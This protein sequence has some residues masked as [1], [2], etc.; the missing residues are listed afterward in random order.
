MKMSVSW[1]VPIVCA[2]WPGL[3]SA[4]APFVP[5]GIESVGLQRIVPDTICFIND[6]NGD[7]VLHAEIGNWEPY[8]SVLGNS[9]FLIESNTYAQPVDPTNLMQRFGLVVQAADGS[10][11]GLG[12]GFFADD[13]TPLQRPHQQLPPE[14]EPG[15]GGGGQAARGGELH[16][17]W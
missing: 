5:G 9:V 3:L 4:Q 7:G 11:A 14:R 2:V 10:A 15:A 16:R 1:I 6:W 13:G 17:R 12:E 8:T